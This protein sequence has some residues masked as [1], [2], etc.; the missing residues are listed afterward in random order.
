MATLTERP[1]KT[2][3]SYTVRWRERGTQQR[4]TFRRKE[5]AEAWQHDTA[6]LEPSTSGAPMYRRMGFEPLTTYLEAVISPLD[7]S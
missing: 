3:T 6:V 7:G 1:G 2:G 5:E 4:K